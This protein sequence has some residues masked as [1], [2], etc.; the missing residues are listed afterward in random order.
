MNSTVAITLLIYKLLLIAVGWWASSRTKNNEDFFLGGRQLGP[1][2]AALSY[3]AS[4]SSAWT[5]L[6][7]SGLAYIIGV[8]AFW[9][10]AGATLGA[11]F[12]WIWVA[13]RLMQHSRKHNQLTLTEFLADSGSTSDS[14]KRNWTMAI[15]VVATLITLGA[16]IFYI[17]AQFQGAGNTFETTFS[18]GSTKSV[19]LGGVIIL[20]YTL[21]GGFWAVSLTDAIQGFM[22]LV[23]SLLLP[24][25]AF[26]HVGGWSGIVTQLEVQG[27]TFLLS[28][29]LNNT[30]LSA[31][32]F[33]L[34][35]LS[36]GIS[37][38]G[39]PHLVTRFM[40]LRDKKALAQARII[41]I[42]W[43][44]AVFFG[45]CILGLSV[46]AML[47]ALTNPEVLFFEAS[48]VLLPPI[49]AGIMIAAVLSAIMSTAD[50]MLLVGAAAVSHDLKANKYFKLAPLTISRLA[51]LFL[52][53]AAIALAVFLPS[54]IF[55]RALFAWVA[56]GSAFGPIIVMKLAGFQLKGEG[57]LLSMLASFGLAAL[58]YFL[59]DTPGDIAE[60]TLPFLVGILI[61]FAFKSNSRLNTAAKK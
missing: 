53:V 51:M 31:F 8:G 16:F 9:L 50:S 57:V 18:I 28:P 1:F 37:A 23:A 30:G 34:G 49:F 11:A 43:F 61:L 60:R 14:D 3:S 58:L 22:M 56:V 26:N 12:A 40:A 48:T 44:A 41:T 7:M 5:L 10:A 36:V 25:L 45:M 33:V 21:M 20:I 27:A 46:K 42:A 38:L 35:G 17:S 2:V 24:I 52:S 13:P 59:P 19:I 4:S 39:Q 32:G 15:R 29:S 47:P 55:D 54:S 6:G